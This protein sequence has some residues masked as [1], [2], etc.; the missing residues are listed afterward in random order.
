MKPASSGRDRSGWLNN[1][2]TEPIIS[3]SKFPADDM[4]HTVVVGTVMEDKTWAEDEEFPSEALEAPAPPPSTPQGTR[5][6]PNERPQSPLATEPPPGTRAIGDEDDEEEE[7]NAQAPAAPRNAALGR[8]LP[9]A[10]VNPVLDVNLAFAPGSAAPLARKRPPQPQP[11]PQ[12][13][14]QQP[15]PRR[16]PPPLPLP[17]RPPRLQPPGAA[18]LPP[19]LPRGFL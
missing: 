19:K 7:R 11:P 9:T 2:V 13:P 4:T 16:P 12:P 14:P 10:V 6:P 15:L 3:P 1:G 17:E 5:P 8:T 18:P